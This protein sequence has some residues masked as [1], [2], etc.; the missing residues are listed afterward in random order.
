MPLPSVCIRDAR[1]AF[2]VKPR[3]PDRFTYLTLDVQDNEEQNLI[4][5]FPRYVL[6]WQLPTIAVG[7]LTP[8][9]CTIGVPHALAQDDVYMG[10][11]LPKGALVTPNIW[12]VDHCFAYLKQLLTVLIFTAYN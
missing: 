7:S 9:F 4:S 3:F 2:S 10:Y 11:K 1:E 6:S 8:W 12:Y 5:L